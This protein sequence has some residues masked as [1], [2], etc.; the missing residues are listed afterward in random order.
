MNRQRTEFAERWGVGKHPSDAHSGS[1]AQARPEL[2]FRR[3]VRQVPGLRAWIRRF[4]R[5]GC[6]FVRLDPVTGEWRRQ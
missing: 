3:A 4:R 1:A 2:D 5:K 6:T